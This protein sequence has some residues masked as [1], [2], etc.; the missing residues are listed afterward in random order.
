MGIWQPERGT[1]IRLRYSV[2][3]GEVDSRYLWTV[4]VYFARI[5]SNIHT[6]RGC[7]AQGFAIRYPLLVCEHNVAESVVVRVKRHRR[8]Q[9]VEAQAGRAG[10]SLP[11]AFPKRQR[12]ALTPA[13]ER[14]CSRESRLVN[15]AL[16]PGYHTHTQLLLTATR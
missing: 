13:S 9:R 2:Y 10:R 4:L 5:R 12:R 7:S 6:D 15:V 14:A 1:V 3:D 8:G 11:L 16:D